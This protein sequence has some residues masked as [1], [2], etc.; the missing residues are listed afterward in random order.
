MKR[1]PKR[2]L[3]AKNRKA[4]LAFITE[5][6]RTQQIVPTAREVSAALGFKSSFTAA[7]HIQ[8]LEQEGYLKRLGRRAIVLVARE[9]GCRSDSA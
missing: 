4:V 6:I 2:D 9:G 5:H 7:R 8:R 3:G 1:N